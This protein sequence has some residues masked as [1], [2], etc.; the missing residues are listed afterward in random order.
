MEQDPP[1][2]ATPTFLRQWGFCPNFCSKSFRV[3]TP[4]TGS[5]SKLSVCNITKCNVRKVNLAFLL[6]QGENQLVLCL[7]VTHKADPSGLISWYLEQRSRCEFR[8]EVSVN[9]E[10]LWVIDGQSLKVAT[11]SHCVPHRAETHSITQ[12]LLVKLNISF[13]FH[14]KKKKKK[15]P[16]TAHRRNAS[17]NILTTRGH[18]TMA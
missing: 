5:N 14:R 13:I 2:C 12:L 17:L 7:G 1:V 3:F 15:I 16:R 9:S 11:P 18:L 4:N 6:H 8:R 10:W